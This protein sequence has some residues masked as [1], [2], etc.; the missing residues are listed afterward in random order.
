[1]D[2]ICSVI[3]WGVDKIFENWEIL[4]KKRYDQKIEDMEAINE[5]KKQEEEREKERQKELY[6]DI[7]EAKLLY[8]EFLKDKDK[9]KKL[10]NN[11]E[12]FLEQKG[13]LYSTYKEFLSNMKTLLDQVN[14]NNFYYSEIRTLFQFH[15]PELKVNI[16]LYIET[17]KKNKETEMQ[18][19][20]M[21]KLLSSF[22]SRIVSIQD[23]LNNSDAENLVYKMQALREVISYTKNKEE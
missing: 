4:R 17:V 16:K 10:L 23:N 18:I 14:L 8:S 6:K 3:E 22:N 11:A 5:Q 9:L 12:R 13:E 1:M 19:K 21:I 7:D 20:E 2:A 15:L